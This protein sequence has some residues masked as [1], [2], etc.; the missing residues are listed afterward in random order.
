[1]FDFYWSVL[2]NDIISSLVFPYFEMK[3]L[4]MEFQIG[5]QDGRRILSISSQL[6]MIQLQRAWHLLKCQMR[7][8]CL[9]IIQ[10][11]ATAV[12]LELFGILMKNFQ[13]LLAT[14]FEIQFLFISAGQILLV[15][16]KILFLIVCK[17]IDTEIDGYDHSMDSHWD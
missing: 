8:S 17:I 9:V 12:Y 3:F 2:N 4:Q 11:L 16:K 13:F 15:G 14:A 6:H 5:G 7:E 10:I 1:M